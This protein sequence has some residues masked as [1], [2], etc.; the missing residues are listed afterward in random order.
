MVK[1]TQ[2]AL[3]FLQTTEAAETGELERPQ[4]GAAARIW[5]PASKPAVFEA[6]QTDSSP[7]QPAEA[8]Q[9]HY[10]HFTE[11]EIMVL[12]IGVAVV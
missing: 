7:A 6:L 2:K 8:G 11:G 1:I 4:K 10:S 9:G 3:H 5:I 12:Y